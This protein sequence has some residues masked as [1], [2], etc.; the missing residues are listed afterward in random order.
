M[1]TIHN[2][3]SKNWITRPTDEEEIELFR[4]FLAAWKVFVPDI[5]EHTA[6]IAQIYI[7]NTW[8]NYD[9]FEE[10]WGS[11]L[12]VKKSTDAVIIQVENSVEESIITGIRIADCWG[13]TFH[14][15]DSL[16]WVIHAGWKWVAAGIIQKT[17]S[18][19]KEKM[20]DAAFSEISF[21]ISPM[22]ASGYEFTSDDFHAS[23]RPYIEKIGLKPEEYFVA[24]GEKWELLLHDLVRDSLKTCGARKI[25]TDWI[26]TLSLD[27]PFPSHRRYSQWVESKT[28]RFFAWIQRN[29]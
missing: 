28:G 9:G 6:N 23:I 17:V 16:F 13:I 10:L 15:N 4:D 27:N 5:R 20:W 26:N 7:S 11:G 3:T 2:N 1:L 19:L 14:Y 24:W 21:A 12:F 29:S 25:Q 18:I 8:N 22:A